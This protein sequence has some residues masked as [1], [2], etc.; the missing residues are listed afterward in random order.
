MDKNTVIKRNMLKMYIPKF[1]TDS[2]VSEMTTDV[3]IR[4]VVKKENADSK[5]L[6]LIKLLHAVYTQTES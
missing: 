1:S 4:D 2:I 6:P 5:L 3:Y